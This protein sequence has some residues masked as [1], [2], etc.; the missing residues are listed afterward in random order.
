MGNAHSTGDGFCEWVVRDDVH[1]STPWEIRTLAATH[2]EQQWLW[3]RSLSQPSTAWGKGK[4]GPRPWGV[5][6]C[7][8]LLTKR[9]R[10]WEDR[11]TKALICLMFCSYAWTSVCLPAGQWMERT[12]WCVVRTSHR[13]VGM[14]PSNHPSIL[15]RFLHSS[16]V[17]M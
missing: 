2:L 14:G 4:R 17:T 11:D 9:N 8:L 12:C 6:W 15:K 16:S 3:G 13:W 10:N 7:S 1:S 5:T